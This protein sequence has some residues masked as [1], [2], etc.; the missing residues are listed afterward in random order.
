MAIGD[1]RTSRQFQVP[2]W[3]KTLAAPLFVVS[4]LAHG[5]LL[6]TP[7]PSNSA[8]ELE[9]EVLEEEEFVDLLSISSL[10]TPEPEP[11][12]ELPST[13]PPEA[14]PPPA[15]APS[16]PTQPVVPE[17]YPDTPPPEAAP[18]DALSPTEEGAFDPPSEQSAVSAPPGEVAAIADRLARG[19]GSNFDITE[20]SFPGLAYDI[21]RGIGEWSAQDQGCFFSQISADSYETLPNI[22]SLRYWSRN[23]GLIQ[24]EDLPGNFPP[25]EHQIVDLGSYCQGTLFEIRRDDQV[26][27]FVSIV[28]IGLGNPQS[29]GLVIFWGSDPRPG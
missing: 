14:A 25:P 10:S 22:A 24:Q 15:S 8:P 21:P 18:A 23:V 5:L 2:G 19:Q 16:A 13:L 1:F 11:E 29:T 3:A 27:I 20:T 4:L 12:P 26:S 6:V 9:E 17:V 7:V 28:G